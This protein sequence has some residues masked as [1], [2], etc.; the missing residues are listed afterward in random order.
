MRA[1]EVAFFFALALAAPACGGSATKADDWP[2]GLTMTLSGDV[3]F[4][5]HDGST[6]CAT[7][8][9]TPGELLALFLPKSNAVL[10]GIG[11]AIVGYAPGQTGTGLSATVNIDHSDGRV[12]Y[13]LRCTVDVTDNTALG[14]A[15]DGGTR[16]RVSASGQCSG[17]AMASGATIDVSPF[18]LTTAALR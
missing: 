14:G 18:Q 15:V 17:P 4:E 5:A 13:D 10:T 16:Y 11:V 1:R 2:C 9:N 12:F 8:N 6:T 7:V 3:A